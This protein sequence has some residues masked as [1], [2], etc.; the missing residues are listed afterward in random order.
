MQIA[1]WG[2][3]T[4]WSFC[5]SN[6]ENVKI[7]SWKI[8]S[9]RRLWYWT[10]NTDK[11]SFDRSANVLIWIWCIFIFTCIRVLGSYNYLLTVQK[12]SYDS[13]F[14][15]KLYTDNNF[16]GMVLY[17]YREDLAKFLYSEKS[18]GYIIISYKII[19]IK[20][21]CPIDKV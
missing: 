6:G 2:N 7:K 5:N 16:I 15:W 14:V 18:C 1:D 8:M 10:E 3:E 13:E 19:I 11:I 12:Y 17:G 20:S 4:H 9:G 21:N